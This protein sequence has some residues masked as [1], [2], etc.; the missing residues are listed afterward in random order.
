MNKEKVIRRIKERY[1]G[2]EIFIDPPEADDPVEIIVEIEPSSEHS[3]HS[4]ALAV[5]GKSALHYHKES[6]E[7]YEAIEGELKVTVDGKVN[8]VKPGEQTMILPRQLHNAEGEEAWFLT[9]SKPGWTMGDH[10]VWDTVVGVIQKSWSAQSSFVPE[11]WSP[12]NPTR[13]QCAVTAIIVQD[14][15]GGEIMKCDV[16]GDAAHFYNKTE[17]GQI[18]DLT[19]VQFDE[20]VVFGVEKVA[21]REII[22]SYPGTQERYEILKTKVRSFL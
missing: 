9:H 20:S 21:D 8:I 7:V 10:L 16:A 2:K 5:V 15:L 12:R 22:L 1:P 14:E 11:E 6:T 19:R 17:G 4:V 18:I 13:G 3:E